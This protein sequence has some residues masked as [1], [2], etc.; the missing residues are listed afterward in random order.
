MQ[1]INSVNFKVVIVAT[2]ANFILG[3]LWYSPVLFG[4]QWAAELSIGLPDMPPVLSI[5]GSFL[6]TFLAMWGV[7]YA[8]KST[9]Q[10]GAKSG[11]LVSLFLSIVVV[12]PNLIGQ[13]FFAGK[14]ILFVIN[15]S[16]VLVIYLLCGL[17]IGHFQK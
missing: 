7:A 2:F 12:T 9:G 14:P 11:A 17:I 15:F 13:W 3:F 6:F 4:T 10:K 16:F 5:I 1:K 8:L